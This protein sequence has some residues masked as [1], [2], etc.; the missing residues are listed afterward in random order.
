MDLRLLTAGFFLAIAAHGAERDV[1]QVFP[2]QPGCTLKVDVDRGGITVEESDASEVRVAI[3]VEI[4]ADTE[5]EADRLGEALQL[6][7]KAENNIVSVRARNP[8]ETGVRLTW[9]DDNPIDLTCKI[10]VPRRCNVVLTTRH[11]GITVGSLQGRVVAR[12]GTGTVFLHRIDGSVDARTQN[13]DVIVSRC[14]GAAV[15]RTLGG[16]IR[17]GTMGGRVDLKN[18]GG[19]IEVQ[20]AR[21]G[22]TAS[23]DVGDV[24]VGFPRD[25][26]GDS[27][28]NASYGN[29]VA[30]IDPAAS[31]VVRASSVWGRVQSALPLA[32]ESGGNGRSQLAGRLNQGGPVLTLHANGGQVRITAGEALFE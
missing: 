5:A 9:R 24:T 16:T 12:T 20:A 30:K 1:N 7:I 17:A 31:C 32:V 28:I 21:A 2:V 18:S 4:G 25:F 3:H 22:L 6:E 23:A 8:V 14:S 13:G 15:L 10:F 29:I 26:S 27:E 19:D 11:G